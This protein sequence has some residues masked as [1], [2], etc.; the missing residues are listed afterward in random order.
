MIPFV[1]ERQHLHS[2]GVLT[3][4]VRMYPQIYS[5]VRLGF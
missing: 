3:E 1:G 5:L 4:R 2:S